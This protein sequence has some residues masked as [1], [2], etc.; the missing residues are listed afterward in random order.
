MDEHGIRA[1]FINGSH[2]RC[3]VDATAN[4]TGAYKVRGALARISQSKNESSDTVW[5][6]SAGNHG[7]GVALAARL[8]GRKAIVYVPETAPVVKCEKIASFGATVIRTGGGFDECLENAQRQQAESG[9]K[10]T[11]VH[12]FDDHVIAAGQGTLALEL[13]EHLIQRACVHHSSLVRLFVPIGGGGL[14]AGMASVLRTI[15]NESLPRLEIIGVVDESSPAALVGTS[16]GRPVG[17]LP[18]TVADG[19]RVARVGQTFLDA[20][21]L[22]DYLMPVPHDEIVTAM[23]Q[24]KRL[25]GELLEP[26]GALAVAGEALVRRNS[27][28]PVL[29]SAL[30][31]AVVSGRNVDQQTFSSL[32]GQPARRCVKSQCRI[33]YQ[34]HI[35]ERD[36][37]LLR[38]LETFRRFNIASLTYQQRPAAE[39]GSLAVHFDLLRSEVR[40]LHHQMDLAFP[41]SIRLPRSH[42]SLVPVAQPVARHFQDELITLE[43]RPGSFADYIQGLK[44]WGTLGSVGYL[45]YRQPSQPGAKAQVVIGKTSAPVSLSL[46]Q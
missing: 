28:L 39:Y 40:E 24:Y 32:V 17:A 3:F 35:P 14:M 44:N 38:L 11:F 43:D 46:V 5:T 21:H 22:I 18:D 10:A 15:W 25:T 45:F 37:E 8:F 7:A 33:G 4:E 42:A 9:T 36:G 27:L 29:R 2:G 13:Y 26:S 12:P 20:A 23:R 19:T 41:G 31:Y 1:R 30:H 6:V 34:V 16:F